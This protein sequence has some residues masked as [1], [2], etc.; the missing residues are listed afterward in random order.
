M[1]MRVAFVWVVVAVL[2]VSSVRCAECNGE[3]TPGPPNLH[4]IHT[5]PPVLVKSVT[6]GKH[7]T[8]GDGDDQVD[9]LHLYGT[10]YDWGK[11][12]GELMKDKLAK[13]YPEVQKYLE[14]QLIKKA[15]NSSVLAWIAEVGIDTALDM[16]YAVT[17]RWTPSYVME[18]IRGLSDGSGVAVDKVRRLMWMG[19]LTRG[20]CSMFGAWGSATQTRGGKLLQLR[21]LDW[22]VDGPFKNYPA[23]VVYHPTNSSEGHSFANLGF[24][25]WTAS[26]TGMSSAPLAVSEIGVSYPDKSFG[27]ST[28]LTPGYPFGFLIRDVL[29]FDNTLTEAT[30]RIVNAKRTANLLLG[31]G[32]GANNAFR[33]FQYSPSTANIFDD[34]NL[35]PLNE[36]WHPR[37]KDVVYW[38]MDWICPNDN[39]MLSH[40]LKALHGN[41]TV[42]NTIRDI[43]PYV[44]T[45]PLA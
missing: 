5:S 30:N 26:I 18:E 32:D 31:V 6:N 1:E 44:Q 42:A 13:F 35:M 37:I 19:E 33:G 25:G 7:F 24:I 16:S 22:D 45:G 14:T 11:A 36:S 34:Q 27:K 4:P 3:S 39:R 12:H 2:C 29:Q 41:I 38:G 28:Y 10:P 23:L 21:A 15:A 8:I 17:K 20:A 40:Q 9:L 43:V